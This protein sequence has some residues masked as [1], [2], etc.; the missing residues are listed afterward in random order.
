MRTQREERRERWLKIYYGYYSNAARGK[1][2]RL[3]L[4]E[5]SPPVVV[6]DAPD[7]RTCRKSWARS[8]RGAACL[9][10]SQVWHPDE[11]NIEA[12]G[13]VADRISRSLPDR[14]PGLSPRLRSAAEADR[15]TSSQIGRQGTHPGLD[16]A[17]GRHG[18]GVRVIS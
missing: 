13:N 2:K 10:P 16:L 8:C 18:K 12:S 15:F 1:R 11:G 6:D 7:K 4:E 5:V 17:V 14:S 3:G 9:R